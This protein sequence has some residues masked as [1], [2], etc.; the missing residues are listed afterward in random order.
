[1]PQILNNISGT[2]WPILT[3]LCSTQF[4]KYFLLFNNIYFTVCSQVLDKS[5][6]VQGWLDASEPGTGNWLKY[7]RS[8]DLIPH[9][10][11]M[12]VQV[13]EQVYN[14]DFGCLSVCLSVCLYVCMSVRSSDLVPHRNVMAVQVEEQVYNNFDCLSVC[15]SVSLSV[16][17]SVCPLVRLNPSS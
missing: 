10:N 5:G 9:R 7:V 15:L 17:L 12:A 6:K 14:D 8:S 13:E 11:V 3:K 16:C 1:M 2:I 4:S